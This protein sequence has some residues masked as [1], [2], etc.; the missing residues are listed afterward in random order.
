M[1]LEIKQFAV[2]RIVAREKLVFATFVERR[3]PATEILAFYV[4]SFHDREKRAKRVLVLVLIVTVVVVV[5][6]V[7]RRIERFRSFTPRRGFTPDG[8]HWQGD[9]PIELHRED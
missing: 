9:W 7:V 2:D 6:T 8:S 5:V 3:N 1:L 4:T